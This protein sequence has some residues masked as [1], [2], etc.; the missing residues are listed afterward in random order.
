MRKYLKVFRTHEEYLEFTRTPEF[1]K[2]N[3]SHCIVEKHVHY[4][5]K[6]FADDYLTFV[7]LENG[8]FQL[9]TNA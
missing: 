5:P 1:L 2:P 3:V 4:N 6:R 7:A 9:S 8:T